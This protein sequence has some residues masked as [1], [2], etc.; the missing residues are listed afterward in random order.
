MAANWLDPRIR[1]DL[2]KSNQLMEDEKNKSATIRNQCKNLVVRGIKENVDRKFF[3]FY[4]G[5]NNW[6]DQQKIKISRV[7][8]W[9]VSIA[10]A[11]TSCSTNKELFD[12]L[13]NYWVGIDTAFAAAN[14]QYDQKQNPH[15]LVNTNRIK[16]TGAKGMDFFLDTVNKQ[17]RGNKNKIRQLSFAT[18]KIMEGLIFEKEEDVENY[19]KIFNKIFELIKGCD[20]SYKKKIFKTNPQSRSKKTTGNLWNTQAERKLLDEK[21]RI[22]GRF[23]A[24]KEFLRILHLVP[25]GS[26][27]GGSSKRKRRTR[28]KTRRRTRRKTRTRTRKTRKTRKTR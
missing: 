14:R 20:I 3:H 16:G 24:I 6:Y 2:E 1:T 9:A 21:K 17:A 19:L 27:V 23:K 11:I 4:N 26:P 10:E 5:G 12:L 25:P 13:R 18:P 22:M 28:R 7:T 15:I 8:K